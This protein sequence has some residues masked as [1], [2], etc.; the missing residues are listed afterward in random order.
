[1]TE[2]DRRL[3]CAGLVSA[4][5]MGNAGEAGAAELPPDVVAKA[6]LEGRV[7]W[8][9]DLVVDQVV[10]SIAAAFQ[11]TYG[12]PVS[13]IRG[14]SQETILKITNEA[15]A[16]RPAADVFSITN[17]MRTL[18]EANAVASFEAP[19]AD[20]LPKDYRSQRGQWV[21]TNIYSMTPAVNTDLVSVADRPKTYEDLLLPRWTTKMVWKPN[22]TSGAPGFIGNILTSKG[23]ERGLEYLRRLSAQKIKIVDVSARGLLDQV[24]A[25]TYPL[26]LQIFNH[27]AELSAKLGAPV[28]WLP[29]S[30][31]AVVLDT[32]G[33]I[34][35]CAHPNAALLLLNYLIS[36][37]GQ[38]IMQQAHYLPS[39]PSVP[40]LD[41]S[42]KPEG[43]R[44]TG[45]VLTPEII[46][47][48]LDHWND[49]FGHLFR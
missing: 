17:G 27:H 24:I 29:F 14:D 43:G 8:Y 12:I 37:R 20:A 16:G 34:H 32:A 33:M 47:K 2:I 30:P 45:N 46:A 10:R 42:L 11:Q 9:T 44:F 3:F 5:F 38:R 21:A 25:G 15:G 28:D 13:Y 1:M 7:V 26:V 6:K 19:N 22:D 49:I 41:P 18:V 4:S 39:S 48:G 23:E 36:A 31:S 35:G 40:A